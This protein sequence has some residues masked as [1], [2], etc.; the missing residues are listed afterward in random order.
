M[1]RLTA[2]T[3]P[4]RGPRTMPH[5]PLLPPTPARPDAA[6]AAGAAASSPTVPARGIAA[7][8]ASGIAALIAAMLLL[9]A[10]LG[11]A[12]PAH[13]DEGHG[14]QGSEGSQGDSRSTEERALEQT[15]S[16]DERVVRER[17]VIPRGHVDMGP[18]LVDGQWRL[19]LRD[20]HDEPVWRFPADTVLA[21][22]D[23][24][25]LPKPD[26][27]RYG[28]V[29]ADPGQEVYVIPQTEAEGIVW[30]GWNTQDPEVHEVLGTGAHLTLEGVRGPGQ[31]SL[32]LE[33]G[34]FSE[35]QLLWDSAKDEEQDIWVPANTHTHANWV[36]TEPGAYAV[37]V[38]VHATLKD[39]TEVSD[40]QDLLFA[41][42]SE[43]D[44]EQ[45]FALAGAGEAAAEETSGEASEGAGSA[46]SAA[47]AGEHDAAGPGPLT[48]ALGAAL[49][50][51]AIVLIGVTLRS[52]RARRETERGGR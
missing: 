42:G 11:G 8:Y 49:L 38:R 45:A 41:V 33:N 13:G 30:P 40:T 35:P 14:S 23:D 5:P 48:L 7:P 16:A 25:L 44:S 36:F 4:R 47:D 46:A 3:P 24:A 2:R 22:S 9:L 18:K 39:G 50:A 32:Y 17:T 21:A 43:T 31:M 34:D 1:L 6:R 26:D 52:R 27:P 29:Q 10:V 15:L 37:T 20:D 51:L 28:F 19:M 12:A